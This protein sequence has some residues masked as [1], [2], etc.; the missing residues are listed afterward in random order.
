MTQFI[1]VEERSPQAHRKL[2]V[3]TAMAFRDGF[4]WA[5]LGCR[6]EVVDFADQLP[7]VVVGF[8][9]ASFLK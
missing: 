9:A 1:A 2:R 5:A 3:S 6:P 4:L 8:H 7:A